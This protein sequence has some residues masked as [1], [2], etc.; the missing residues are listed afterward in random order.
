MNLKTI[1]NIA[2]ISLVAIVSSCGSVDKMKVTTE[3]NGDELSR[4][5]FKNHSAKRIVKIVS[6]SMPIVD[7]IEVKKISISMDINGKKSSLR[8]SYKMI[9]DSI[10]LLSAHK[11]SIPVAKAKFEAEAIDIVYY[12]DKVCFSS[13]WNLIEE[14]IGIEADLSLF[15]SLF[16]GRLL[17]E[18]Y[19]DGDKDIKRYK[20]TTDGKYYILH[21][22]KERRLNKVKSSDSKRERYIDRK[23]SDRENGVVAERIFINPDS[24]TI[25]KVEIEDI[26]T[27]SLTKIYYSEYKVVDGNI[28]PSTILLEHINKLGELSTVKLSF[29]RYIVG[30]EFS[31][32]F[33]IPSK[34]KREELKP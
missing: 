16:T 15:Q 28:L 10:M 9:H 19:I 27:N 7:T 14:K 2:V 32:S 21:S 17:T 31:K 33:T 25:S 20:S 18:S 12:I 26:S 5:K 4:V 22:L 8:A 34:Y 13:G 6:D 3:A 23:E 24:Y 29:S 1:V 30:G 11:V